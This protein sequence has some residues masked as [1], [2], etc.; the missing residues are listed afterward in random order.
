MAHRKISFAIAGLVLAGSM[1]GLGAC[2]SSSDS[3]TTYCEHLW[4]IN[5]QP[6]APTYTAIN[7][8]GLYMKNCL[9]QFP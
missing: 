6:S 7:N 3:E 2:S 1:L 8:R 4:Q 9:S 5:Q